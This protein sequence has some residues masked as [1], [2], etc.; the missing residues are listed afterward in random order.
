MAER[1]SRHA[2]GGAPRRR[3]ASALQFGCGKLYVFV[4]GQPKPNRGATMTD[5][6]S[7]LDHT[8][9]WLKAHAAEL[10]LTAVSTYVGA[11]AAFL[12]ERRSRRSERWSNHL[13]KGKRAQVV[14]IGQYEFLLKIKFESLAGYEG[15]SDRWR[16][17][18][19]ALV[20]GPPDHVDLQSLSF[21][22]ENSPGLI[23]QLTTH[24]YNIATAAGVLKARSEHYVSML[25]KVAAARAAGVTPEYFEDVNIDVVERLKG[26]TDSLYDAFDVAI[27]ST[28]RNYESLAAAMVKRFGP[29]APIPRN[30]LEEV[31]RAWEKNLKR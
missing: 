4:E 15:L 12:F 18:P 8:L 17:L 24:D 3:P 1:L 23:H 6:V 31:D 7:W 27:D 21:L 5:A 2:G 20:F 22:L 19:A 16:Q 28:C 9:A 11:A 30:A 10:F 13:I 26:L 25:S 14:M 29:T